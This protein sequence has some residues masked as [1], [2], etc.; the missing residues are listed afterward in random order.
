M[1]TTAAAL[2]H[3]D[4]SLILSALRHP[5][6]RYSAERASQ[7]SGIPART[8]H[9][10]ATSGAMMPDWIASTPR[11]WSF[12]DLVYARLLAWLR[13][14]HMDRTRA[15][16][17]VVAIRHQMTDAVVD[18]GIRSDGQIVLLGDSHEDGFTGQ[19]VFHGITP[20]LHV[21]RLTDPIEGV[22]R[23]ELWGPNLVNPSDHTYISPWVLHGE[24]CVSNSRVP[25]SA[26]YALRLQRGLDTDQ[27]GELYP[28]LTVAAID[29]AIDLETRL[30]VR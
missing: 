13:S 26:L 17:R 29:D 27:I 20:F 11:G 3:D 22:S 8:L 23:A 5:R 14:K 9:D 2:T 21:F 30:R 10:W 12:R 15:A 19:Q 16:E 25:S 6:G 7:L 18:P 1:S 28:Q 4:R 24:P